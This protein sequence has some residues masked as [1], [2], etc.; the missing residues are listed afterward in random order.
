MKVGEDKERAI[1]AKIKRW[2]ERMIVRERVGWVKMTLGS[3]I[4]QVY[5][6]VGV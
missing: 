4:E 6:C 5:I 3:A 2:S 1:Q